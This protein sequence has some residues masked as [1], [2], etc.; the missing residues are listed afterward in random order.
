MGRGIMGIAFVLGIAC[1]S[2][3]ATLGAFVSMGLVLVGLLL[4]NAEAA[5]RID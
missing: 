3:G 5:R 1:A 4:A 2:V